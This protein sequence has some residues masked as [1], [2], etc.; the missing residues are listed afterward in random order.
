MF[1]DWL[2]PVVVWLMML[3]PVV[4]NPVYVPPAVRDQD[5]S[6]AD[7]V[8]PAGDVKLAAPEA[9]VTLN[10]TLALPVTEGPA[11]CTGFAAEST[12][13]IVGTPRAVVVALRVSFCRVGIVTDAVVLTEQPAVVHVWALAV[14]EKAKPRTAARATVRRLRIVCSLQSKCSLQE[15]VSPSAT[16]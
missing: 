7:F 8:T 4:D 2:P 13:S 10:G 5:R 14:A 11:V 15:P 3:A 12:L 6:P 16:V 9:I 1:T